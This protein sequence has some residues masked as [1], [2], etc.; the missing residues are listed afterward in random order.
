MIVGTFITYRQ[1]RQCASWVDTRTLAPYLELA[2]EDL[3]GDDPLP[4]LQ[5]LAR[6]CGVTAG[7]TV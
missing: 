2:F 5:R 6:Q 4:T 7:M 3:M 1:L